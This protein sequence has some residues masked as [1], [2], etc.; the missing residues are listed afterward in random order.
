MNIIPKL[1]YRS[2]SNGYRK[3]PRISNLAVCNREPVT[4]QYI[5]FCF[6]AVVCVV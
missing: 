4:K 5:V 2:L 3:S 6:L 1:V